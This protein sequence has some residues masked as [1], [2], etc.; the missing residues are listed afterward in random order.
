MEF[1]S[2]LKSQEVSMSLSSRNEELDEVK[3]CFSQLKFK[4][5]LGRGGFGAV[6]LA[7]D[8]LTSQTVAVKLEPLVKGKG[9]RLDHESEAYL[10]M[11]GSTRV[12]QVHGLKHIVD[13]NGQE[14][15]AL[16]MERMGASID[17]LM[18]RYGLLS[19]KT[20]IQLGIQMLFA[21]EDVHK[22]GLIH[23]DVKPSNFVL[24]STV[25][26]RNCGLCIIDFGIAFPYRD[27]ETGELASFS[28]N[29]FAGSMMFMSRDAHLA[30]LP[31]QKDDLESFCYTLIYMRKKSLPWDAAEASSTVQLMSVIHEIKKAA[32]IETLCS[33]L[34]EEFGTFLGKIWALE[35]GQEPDYAAYRNLL[36]SCAIQNGVVL[37]W[38]YEWDD[39]RIPTSEK[40]RFS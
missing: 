21:I 27:S 16:G 36:T 12:P 18:W 1:V 6:Y 35:L 10:R 39:G 40:N 14:Y 24:G 25:K 5:L 26:R 32:D 11:S 3:A 31:C 7:L 17:R 30:L 38:T 8:T 2:S 28:K 34:P 37:D 13:Q 9:Y 22:A 23:R 20:V 33:G 29:V 15:L 19:L 4:K